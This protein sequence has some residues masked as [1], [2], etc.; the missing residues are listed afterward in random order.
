MN[1]PVRAYFDEFSPAYRE[2]YSGPRSGKTFNFATRLALACD[3]AGGASGQL[4]DCACGTGEITCALL[5]SGRFESA[6]IVDLS[7]RML[8]QA[9]TLIGGKVPRLSVRFVHSDIFSFYPNANE[10]GYDLIVCL[11][12]I[13]HVG[14]LDELL[15]HL[16]RMLS[17][18]GRIL[19]QTT[20]ADHV[21]TKIVRALTARRYASRHGYAISYYHHADIVAA[22]ARA[23]LQI[24]AMRRHNIGIFLADRLFP[25]LN[26]Q[27][28]AALRGWAARYGTDAIYLLRSQANAERS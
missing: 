18:N 23:K 2:N 7:P 17:S 15:V 22:L 24:V 6:T 16:S 10:G 20:L 11:G 26:Y 9:E 12:L 4:L 21:L 13:A 5:E 14:R 28:E 1:D 8:K 19:L 27:L 25:A 3:L